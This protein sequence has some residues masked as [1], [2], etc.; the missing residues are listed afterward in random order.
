MRNLLQVDTSSHILRKQMVC[1]TISLFDGELSKMHD[2]EVQD[3][4][5]CVLCMENE[6]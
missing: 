5:D 1:E 4:S 3:F 2:A 6:R